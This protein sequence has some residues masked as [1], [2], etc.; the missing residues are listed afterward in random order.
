M[1]DA[2]KAKLMSRRTQS[3]WSNMEV[4]PSWYGMLCSSR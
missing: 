2:K 3:A 1:S 4:V